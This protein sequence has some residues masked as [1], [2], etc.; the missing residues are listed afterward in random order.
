M[1]AVSSTGG[2]YCCPGEFLGRGL[3]QMND[4]RGCRLVLAV[5]VDEEAGPVSTDH[6]PVIPCSDAARTAQSYESKPER[7]DQ[8]NTT[9]LDTQAVH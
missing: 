8:F 1:R 6:T 4:R 5:D 7:T 2:H 3:D 9:K